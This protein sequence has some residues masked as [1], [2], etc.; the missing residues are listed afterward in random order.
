MDRSLCLSKFVHP[1]STLGI[2]ARGRREQFAP[3][4]IRS[5]SRDRRALFVR[6][7]CI[8]PSHVSCSTKSIYAQPKAHGSPESPQV[9]SLSL[10]RAAPLLCISATAGPVEAGAARG[11]VRRRRAF[12]GSDPIIHTIVERC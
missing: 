9:W 3:K 2:C 12:S 4:G 5:T 8:H 11:R 6:R 1:S 7:R 10:S